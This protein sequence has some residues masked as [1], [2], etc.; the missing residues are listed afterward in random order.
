MNLSEQLNDLI[1][2]LSG[3]GPEIWLTISF[4]AVI[5][6]ELI[7]SR[8]SASNTNTLY[9]I[10][11]GV[12]IVALLSVLRQWDTQTD[13]FLFLELLFID[14]KA[15][16]FKGLVSLA[17]I[18]MLLHGWVTH[19]KLAAEFFPLLIGML[20]GLFLLTMAVNLLMVF[21]SIEVISIASYVMTALSQD[22]KSAEG[23]IKY[24]LFGTVSAAIMLYGM[25]LLY[26]LTGTLQ[27][28]SPEFTR[29]ISQA[30]GIVV[31]VAVFLTMSGFLFKISAVPFHIWNPD[32]YESAP[33]PVVSF[34]SVAP[35]AAALL[36]LIRLLSVVPTDIQQPLALVSILSLVI[37]NFSALWQTNVKRL[38]AYSSIA[39]AG[40]ML[41]GL[42]AFSEAGLKSTVFYVATY[43]FVSMAAFLLI[44]VLRPR[45]GATYQLDD[46]QGL[47][48]SHP[49][50]AVLV[51][52]VMIA[53]VGLPLT[54][55]FSAK[56]FVF[57]A[58]W[59]T[60]QSQ[61]STT[62]LVLLIFGLLNAAVS[63]FYYLRLP[64]VMIF[65]EAE[66]QSSAPIVTLSQAVLLW[67]LVI[68]IVLLFF[69]ADW[70]LTIIENL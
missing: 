38:L 68:P 56:L 52:I 8:H 4:L 61:H 63:L 27:V 25:S 67:S 42:V 37:G 18:V 51:I 43:L 36:A 13:G 70:V 23:G 6:V 40:F 28:V 1:V 39:Q 46:Y 41:V 44:D 11:L 9:G 15:L 53:L 20:L 21:L 3:F 17:A 62:L 32:V 34:F 7:L 66:N 49:A 33:T 59:D 24:A 31:F 45:Q 30:D 65:R 57:S 10:T 12:C 64:F 16:F 69:K 58:L 54:V 5:V 50:L 2:S 55:G 60:Y 47:G 48:Q 26:G 19:R 22:R 14:S 29:A 35:K